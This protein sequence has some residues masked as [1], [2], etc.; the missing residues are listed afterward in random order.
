M[1]RAL[2]WLLLILGVLIGL[3]VLAVIAV[4]IAANTGPGQ[5][6]IAS[7]VGALTGGLVTVSGLS[8]TVPQ[9]LRIRRIR[10]ADT[11]GVWLTVEDAALNWSPLDLL[12]GRAH[13]NSLT[14]A[15]VAVARLP[16]SQP[17]ARPSPPFQLPLPVDV[18]HA[19][20]D[21][22][23]VGA[24]VIGTAAA[25]EAD[26][27]AH[28]QRLFQGRAELAAA[29][30]DG[31]GTY[32]ATADLQPDAVHVA[33][34]VG[35]P[36]GGLIARIGK[37]PPQVGALSLI[38]AAN[39]PRDTVATHVALQAGQARADI[40]GTV[41]LDAQ[42]ADLTLTATAPAMSPVPSVAFQSASLDGH[43]QGTL[44]APHGA[45]NVHLAGLAAAGATIPDLSANAIVSLARASSRPRRKGSESPAR[46]RTCWPAR[47]SRSPPTRRST[48]RTARSPSP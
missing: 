7:H 10:I 47:R 22:I 44:K 8:G 9:S 29:N 40:H 5:A 35:E 48:S 16:V 42:S 33:L 2:R 46:I 41:N 39:G 34:T 32:K 20:V 36:P 25:V 38:A 31:P 23:E 45:A 15:R 1:R 12:G 6:F 19:H 27:S 11:R 18:D 3:P 17:A 43:L 14:A 4:L 21:R 24:P 26:A 30:L 37:L 13:V 28:L